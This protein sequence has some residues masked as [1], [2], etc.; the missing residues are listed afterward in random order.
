MPLLRQKGPIT[1]PCLLCKAGGGHG[2]YPLLGQGR[3]LACPTAP[4]DRY[5]PKRQFPRLSN[6]ALGPPGI[7]TAAPTAIG[8]GGKANQSSNTNQYRE[9][10]LASSWKSIGD[11]AAMLVRRLDARRRREPEFAVEAKE[12]PAWGRAKIQR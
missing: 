11:V 2:R 5:G 9:P 1:K 12:S 6:L 3:N 10:P 8:N 4:K 7:E